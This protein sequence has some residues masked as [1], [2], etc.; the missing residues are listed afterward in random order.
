MK[1]NVGMTTSGYQPVEGNSIILTGNGT[2]DSVFDMENMEYWW[3]MD[4]SK[5]SDNDGN[6]SNDIDIRGLMVEWEYN[7]PGN[8]VVQLTVYDG[9][10]SDSMRI[11]ITVQ[12]APFALTDI[13]LNPIFIGLILLSILGI[14]GV[15]MRKKKTP[16]VVSSITEG[17]MVMDDAFDDPEFDPFSKERQKQK[18]SKRRIKQEK[19]KPDTTNP[20]DMDDDLKIEN[21]EE[22]EKIQQ[23][24]EDL[25]A[26]MKELEN[27][28]LSVN[29]VMSTSE[30]EE[31]IGEEE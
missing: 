30:I 19:D 9:D 31:L 23:E 21:E 1:P 6:P 22:Y 29:E 13:I 11:T 12:E 26:K 15:L 17:N 20:R 14:V 3:D 24:M 5:D 4:I 2:T 25:R 18:I 27:K 28:N 10:T 8:K 16:L 7:S